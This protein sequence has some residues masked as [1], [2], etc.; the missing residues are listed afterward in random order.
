M[1]REVEVK[2]IKSFGVCMQGGARCLRA[3][4][5]SA[6]CLNSNLVVLWE[7]VAPGF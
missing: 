3:D 7:I 5:T 4:I 2:S 1:K 6:T